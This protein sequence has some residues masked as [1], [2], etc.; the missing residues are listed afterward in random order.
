MTAPL[1]AQTLREKPQYYLA[2][3][4]SAPVRVEVVL[5]IL[6]DHEPSE[7]GATEAVVKYCECG[8]NGERSSQKAMAAA[9]SAFLKEECK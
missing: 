8:L 7:A 2:K 4:A 9:I 3:C 5:E 1:Q 6:R